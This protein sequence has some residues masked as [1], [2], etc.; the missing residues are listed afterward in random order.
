[1][2]IPLQLGSRTISLTPSL[3]SAVG[4]AFPPGIGGTEARLY[5]EQQPDGPY[6]YLLEIPI[7]FDHA[8]ATSSSSP[9]AAGS[10]RGG[11]PTLERALGWTVLEA[12]L[13]A[14]LYWRWHAGPVLL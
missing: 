9:T 11:P 2:T 13:A 7:V 10:W 6:N 5:S 1:M 14:L 8:F 12:A 4:R 3:M